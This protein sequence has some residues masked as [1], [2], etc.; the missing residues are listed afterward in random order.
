MYPVNMRIKT[1][2]LL[3]DIKG[4]R[5]GKNCYIPKVYSLRGGGG[6]GVRDS[7]TLLLK[8]QNLETLFLNHVFFVFFFSFHVFTARV[9]KVSFPCLFLPITHDGKPC[10][11]SSLLLKDLKRMEENSFHLP[12]FHSTP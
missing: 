2:K 9:L 10:K 1:G 3:A 11:K 5:R 6:G 8:F 12:Y 7:K 4:A